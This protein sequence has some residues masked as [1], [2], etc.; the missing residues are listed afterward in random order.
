MDI[1]KTLELVLNKYNID[2]REDE[3]IFLGNVTVEDN[4]YIQSNRSKILNFI[5][6]LARFQ[7]LIGISNILAIH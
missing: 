2:V 4:V 7:F 3:K 6:E 1:R 5:Q